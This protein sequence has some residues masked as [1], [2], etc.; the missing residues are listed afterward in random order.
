MG[1]VSDQMAKFWVHE[2]VVERFNG[3]EYGVYDAAVPTMGFVHDGTKLLPGPGGQTVTSSAQVAY[4]A[5]T[6]YIPVDSRVTLPALFGGRS[7]TVL[8]C[9]VADAGPLPTPNHLLIGLR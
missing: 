4:P 2:T 9:D 3:N 6:P 1:A 5:G 7:S 8:T